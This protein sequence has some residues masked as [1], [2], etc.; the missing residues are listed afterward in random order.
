MCGA[1]RK[2]GAV[3]VDDGGGRTTPLLPSTD[4]DDD[5]IIRRLPLGA[6]DLDDDDVATHRSCG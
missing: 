1:R 3:V 5:G 6:L 2:V 4:E